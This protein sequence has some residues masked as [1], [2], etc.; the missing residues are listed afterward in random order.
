[1][2]IKEWMSLEDDLRA[3]SAE[4]REKRKRGK[5]VRE[6]IVKIM[7]GNKVG[8]LNISAGT[9]TTKSRN[10]KAPM[11]KKYISE[12]LVGF[13][14]GDRARAEECAAYLE[15]HRMVKTT[16]NLTLDPVSSP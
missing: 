2:L 12:T 1:M 14:G 16:E 9:V 3:L 15:A 11:S 13:F 10:T 7:K 8:R 5:T 4:L 6:M